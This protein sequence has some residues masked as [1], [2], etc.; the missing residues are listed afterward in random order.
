MPFDFFLDFHYCIKWTFA[1]C[2]PCDSQIQINARVGGQRLDFVETL[3]TFLIL[4]REP[5]W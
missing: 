3:K 4:K 1:F 2:Q 5:S